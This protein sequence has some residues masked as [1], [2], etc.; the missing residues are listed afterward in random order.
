LSDLSSRP[1]FGDS[2]RLASLDAFRGFTILGMILVNSPGDWDIAYGPLKH[3]DWNGL[4]FAD[5]I[6]P[7]FLFI[8]GVSIVMAYTKRLEASAP[9]NKIILKIIKRTLIIFAI[10]LFLNAAEVGFT[11]IRI[12]GVLQR[13][14]IVFLVCVILFLYTGWRTQLAI[15]SAILVLYWL[16]M[17]LVPVPGVGVGVVEP[18]QNLAAWI[19]TQLL[20]G[21]M[22]EG[23]WDPEGILSTFP[24]IVSC[25][26]GMFTG[27]LII[28][29]I[30]QER[31]LIWMC[32]AGFLLLI[33]GS[34][35]NWFFPLNKN[36]WSSSFVLF[37]SGLAMM[38]LACFIWIIDVQGYKKWS[39]IFII[40]GTN[41][42][43]AYI[44]HG[45]LKSPFI[46]IPVGDSVE[47]R[48]LMAAFMNGLIEIGIPV[49]L[50]SFT[51]A[52]LFT[53]LCF[54]PVWALYARKIF[55]KV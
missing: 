1:W 5:V 34:I 18:G 28:S 42:I 40:F 11:D 46:L 44:L 19:D 50:A 30:S 21:R 45:I 35:C 17:Y 32:F 27:Y 23:S 20:P 38:A 3:A 37:T 39:R 49:E 8:V 24:A 16:A 12:M 36:I 7:F 31:K 41:A 47:P 33:L 26:T 22:F 14:A 13:I 29:R 25:I 54:F 48:N 2:K 53:A 43:T 51:W 15:G 55:L 10:G 6:F 9:R 4:T 52:I